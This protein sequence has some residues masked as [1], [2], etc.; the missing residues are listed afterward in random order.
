MLRGIE[1]V[2]SQCSTGTPRSAAIFRSPAMLSAPSIGMPEPHDEIADLEAEIAAL[3]NAA[4]RCRKVMFVAKAATLAGSLL[5][6]V[7]LSGLVRFGPVPLVAAITATLGGIA[8]F[9]SHR[10]TLDQITAQ[11]RAHEARRAEL[12]DRMGLQSVRADQGTRRSVAS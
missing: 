6:A 11:I 1:S 10:S 3:V 4:D 5:F 8:L 12:I 2:A 9:G 7:T